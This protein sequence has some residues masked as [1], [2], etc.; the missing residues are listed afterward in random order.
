MLQEN[1]SNGQRVEKFKVFAY[2][3]SSFTAQVVTETAFH[4][5]IHR[6]TFFYS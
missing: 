6:M 3:D 1:I 4:R 5:P 2:S